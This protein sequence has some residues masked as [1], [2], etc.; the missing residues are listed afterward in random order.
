MDRGVSMKTGFRRHIYGR[1]RP[2]VE[3]ET[4]EQRRQAE[5]RY[6]W[7]Y[8][9]DNMFRATKK[10]PKNMKERCDERKRNE[11]LPMWLKSERIEPT[12]KKDPYPEHDPFALYR[13]REK[14]EHKDYS[15]CLAA[16]KYEDMNVRE[17]LAN[18]RAKAAAMPIKRDMARDV[19][20]LMEDM[21]KPL[22]RAQPLEYKVID[23]E[24]DPNWE[25]TPEPGLDDRTKSKI[26]AGQ[27]DLVEFEQMLDNMFGRKGKRGG[28][29]GFVVPSAPVEI[30]APSR[31]PPKV[32][33]EASMRQLERELGVDDLDYTPPPAPVARE[34][35]VRA[36][37]SAR[38]A[39]PVTGA[40]RRRPGSLPPSASRSRV[41]QAEIEAYLAGGA[42]PGYEA[43]VPNGPI[44]VSFAT[45]R[46]KTNEAKNKVDLHKTLL[47]R[48]LPIYYGPENAVEYEVDYKFGELV[49][50]MPELDPYRPRQGVSSYVTPAPST[51]SYGAPIPPY[52]P[53]RISRAQAPAGGLPPK[54]PAFRPE[55]SD[56]RKRIRDVICMTRRD[57]HYYS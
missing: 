49:D 14:R 53:A 3:K 17:M 31:I 45:L 32:D 35:V 5:L 2:P 26:R 4:R 55:M 21:C 23:D 27:A 20:T 22:P 38:G 10:K 7:D 16:K 47:D 6:P 50:R 24:F 11:R 13:P 12:P 37:T 46:A 39:V 57:P 28:G 1:N 51:V 9:T 52:T 48:Y 18:M 44:P 54:A 42:G 40:V 56:T 34:H 41:S 25:Y 19:D 36:R 30:R 43:S 33:M 15:A 8:T 29:G